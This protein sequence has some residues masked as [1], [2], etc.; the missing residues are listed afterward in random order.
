[1]STIYKPIITRIDTTANWTTLNPVPANGEQCIEVLGGGL[2]KLKIGDGVSPWISLDYYQNKEFS[3]LAEV[4]FSGKYE[5][6][7]NKPAIDGVVLTSQTT[8]ED[9]GI[10]D[11]NNIQV[12]EMPEITEEIYGRIVQYVGETTEEYTNGYFYKAERVSAGFV[13]NEEGSRLTGISNIVIDQ[14]KLRD[15]LE[16][17][18]LNL[19][20]DFQADHRHYWTCVS[21]M[22]GS[23]LGIGEEVL[24][25]VWGITW[26]GTPEYV[27]PDL[28]TIIDI[29]E[30][31]EHGYWER[32]DVQPDNGLVEDVL[33][34]GESVV[35][36]KTA[37]ISLSDRIKHLE[38]L[39]V[40]PD[41]AVDNEIVQYIGETTEEYTNGY[42]YKASENPVESII[43]PHAIISGVQDSDVIIDKDLFESYV[44]PE[45]DLELHFIYKTRANS[46]TLNHER[47]DLANYGIS[48]DVEVIPQ[49]DDDLYIDYRAATT[50][51]S[52]TRINVQPQVDISDKQDKDHNEVYKVGFNGG[53]EDANSIINVDSYITKTDAE[54]GSTTLSIEDI[55]DDGS[56]IDNTDTGLTTGKAVY[57]YAQPQLDNKVDKTNIPSKVYGTNENGEQTLYDYDSFGLVDDV[58]VDGE[59][60]V[61]DSIANITL[62]DRIRHLEVLP[63]T[64]GSTENGEIVQYIGLTNQNYTNGYF[65][66]ASSEPVESTITP[67]VISSVIQDSDVTVNKSTF[68]SYVQPTQDM[69]LQFTYNNGSWLLDGEIVNIADYGI[70][71]N[72]TP[73]NDDTLYIDYRYTTVSYNWTRINVQPVFDVINNLTSTSTTDALSANMG[74]ELQ[75]EIE[76]LQARGRFL[77]VWN[78]ATGLPETNPQTSPYEYHTGDYFIV[79]TVANSHPATVELTQTVGNTLSDLEVENIEDFESQLSELVDTTLIF[80]YDNSNWT[81]E[82]NIVDITDYSITYSGT[83]VDGDR[84]RAVYSAE[85]HNY[86][87]NGTEYIIDVASTTV[88]T[89]S[90]AVND[91]YIYDG[92]HWMLQATGQR[93][94]SF[95]GIAGSPYD[96]TNLA[97]ALDE[98]IDDVLVNNVSVVTNNIANIELTSSNIPYVNPDYPNIHTIEDALNQLL[99]IAPTVTLHGGNNYEIGYVVN[100]VNLTWNWNKNIISQSLNQ[101]IGDLSANSRSYTYDTPMTSNT[102]FT[103]TGSDGTRTATSST[104]V[105][106]LPKRYWGVSANTSLTDA[107]ILMLSSELSTS[108]T[109]TRTFD[110]SGGKYFYFVIRTSYCSGISFKVNGLAFT[111]MDVVSRN[112]INAQGFEAA[113]NIYRVHN[114]QTGSAIEVQVL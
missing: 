37:Y 52:W 25:D 51:F 95:S 97:N 15:A 75:E 28:F 11:L 86:K 43:T 2:F 46:W 34:D 29:E 5:D 50:S 17:Y 41:A 108:R 53:W 27:T 31:F 87:P 99:Y 96:N 91:N 56:D 64:P 92:T 20:L 42:F 49:N 77:S 109:Q 81:L 39:G 67:H 85:V 70:S 76:V 100:S 40:T 47:V 48:F 19:P 63:T 16:S 72:G 84:I 103:I 104:S 57:E 9:L 65:Y 114:I 44:Q 112:V 88:E 6:L 36:D 62:S 93:E 10:T 79:G 32:I 59:S 30:L 55:T 71:I 12:R 74:R 73:N 8:K 80:V 33:V 68:E 21:P 105:N 89:E 35:V 58:R 113:Y 61:T 7:K 110:C 83:P 101:G 107:D 106:F 38:V 54:D 26:D 98:K 1:M 78:S 22:G 60:V 3:E 90:V 14:E 24:R 111:D 66:K 4:A 102:T 13:V 45:S 69:E 18:G 23:T 94:V 82:G